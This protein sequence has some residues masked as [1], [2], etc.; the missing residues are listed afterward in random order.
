VSR[1]ETAQYV[2]GDAAYLGVLS[3]TS[4][5]FFYFFKKTMFIQC[6]LVE[7]CVSNYIR[8]IDACSRKHPQK[9][10]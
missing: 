9:I 6:S 3:R 10:N 8:S 7:Q 4:A 2:E 5:V 1:I